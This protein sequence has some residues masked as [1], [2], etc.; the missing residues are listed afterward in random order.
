MWLAIGKNGLGVVGI[1]RTPKLKLVDIM[2][3]IT[4]TSFYV[5]AL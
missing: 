2:P 4:T 5:N 1:I 3:V